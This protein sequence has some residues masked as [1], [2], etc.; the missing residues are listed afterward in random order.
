MFSM[1]VGMVLSNTFQNISV[2][3]PSCKIDLPENCSEPQGYL[4]TRVIGT[5][6]ALGFE[7]HH[8]SRVVV[9]LPTELKP[10]RKTLKPKRYLES[11][12][13]DSENV[14]WKPG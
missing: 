6:E 11:L 1:L 3:Q 14:Y 10:S 8:S 7:Q 12:P 5:I 2:K 4:R 13:D 9:Y